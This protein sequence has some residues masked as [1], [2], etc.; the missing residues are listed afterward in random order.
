[1][2]LKIE[3]Y[4]YILAYTPTKIGVLLRYWAYKPLFKKVDGFFYINRGVI[5]RNFKN[6]SLGRNVNIMENSYLYANDHGELIIGDNFTSNNN[7]FFVSSSSKI[8]IGDNCM[9]GPNCV[10]RSS[11]HNFDRVDI[12]IKQQKDKCSYII[13]EDDVWLASNCV[14]TAEVTIKKG[15]VIGAGSVVLKDVEPYS[16]MG[17]VPAK[18]IKKRI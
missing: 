18:L 7:V 12:P 14:I 3:F 17:G 6:I 8:I 9:V 2:L 4:I 16:L 15:S 10:L 5:I 13:I 1:M 11:N